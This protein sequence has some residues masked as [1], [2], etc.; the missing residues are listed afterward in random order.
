MRASAGYLARHPWQLGLAVLGICIGVAVM[1]A[2]DLA[3]GSA[4]KAFLLS[5][6][7]LNGQ[8]THQVVGGP[9]GLD[10]AVY[11]DLRVRHGLRAVAPV[12][13]GYVSAGG[14]T[15]R[16]LG[17][18]VFAEREFR[19][20]TL[21]VTRP[22]DRAGGDSPEALIRRFLTGAG[23]LLLSTTD[24]TRLGVRGG[25]E[26]Q[27]IA[28]GRSY[29]ATV[30]GVLPDSDGRYTGLVVADIAVAQHW[31]GMTG[32]LSRIDV[33]I[34]APGMPAQDALAALLPPGGTLLPTDDRTRTT[35]QMSNA[36]MTNLT[37]M[38]LLAMLVGVFLIYNSIAFA[39]VQR[40]DLIGI[41]RALGVTRAQAFGLI[42]GE[43]AALGLLGST[44]GLALG[45]WLGGHL[46]TLV[47]RT[48]SDHYFLVNVTGIVLSAGSL[49]K[50]V[51]AGLGATLVAAAV[52]ALE[53]S[54]YA[55]RLALL[56]SGIE[57]R[58]GRAAP[59]LAAAGA[60]LTALA[61]LALAVSGT[62]LVAA[63]AALFALV[64]GVALCI[65]ALVQIAVPFLSPLAGRL[66][67]VAGRLAVGGIGASMS[68]TA[69]AIV[70]LAVA[71]SATIGVS[72]MVGS[73][74]Q[75]VSEWLG[76]SLR[77]D[78]YVAV[79][80][81][82]LDPG[83]VADLA[84]LPAVR[85][86]SLTRRSWLE[87]DGVRTR[88]IAIEMAAPG[89][90]GTRLRDADPAAAWQAFEIEGAVLVSDAYAWRRG[91]ER[92]DRIRL[93][94]I[95]GD[96][97][98]TIAGVY[99]S[100][101]SGD[102]ALMMSRRH[103]QRLFADPAI[104]SMGLYLV[105]GA[106]PDAVMDQV[107]DTAAGR[108]SIVVESNARLREISLGIFDRT[109]LITNVLYWL[110]VGVAVIGIL[111]ALLA[112]Q[113]ERGREIGVLRALG[114]TPLQ[115]GGL[116]TA[117]SAVIGLFAG[118]AALP[119]GLAMAWVLVAVIDRR[120]FGWQIELEVA[121]GALVAALGLAVGAAVVGGLYP[122]W[123]AASRPPA[124]A[125]RDE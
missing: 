66:G 63:L 1:V 123:K 61:G 119:L 44:A 73:F 72:L 50:A 96:V 102:G 47:A 41:L 59:L 121:P 90:A 81:G 111:G 120:A 67:G 70:A 45:T 15:M 110:A 112:L 29:T 26:L 27:L 106:E 87:D 86:R 79:P 14:E 99:Q 76:D 52:P 84:A 93:R 74:R 62:S 100:Y 83:L 89:Y 48:V 64:L 65:P 77:A 82:S 54:S 108:Q 35:V 115:T 88:I 58:A 69:V 107:R 6:D 16:L 34:D 95:A 85:D 37:A 24:A 56:R 31:L 92:G 43:A 12:V 117:Q 60:V 38:S 122:A 105:Q 2:V 91:V 28:D 3:N 22:A 46:L 40:R 21:P 114:M 20:W 30:A 116:V 25:D 71:V 78:L 19:D 39:V 94:A 36:F 5:M 23:A 124:L 7:A 118:I 13:T 8:A 10:E 42:A 113:L 68:R 9:A 103:Y 57:S 104:D 109:F 11:R 4:R 125:I 33:R 32:R 53:A 17:I 101:D 80:G 18:D 75:S 55:P 51:A 97:E 98:V 49:A